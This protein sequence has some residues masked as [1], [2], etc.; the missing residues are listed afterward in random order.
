MH[1]SLV[2]TSPASSLALLTI[3]ELREAAGVSGSSQDTKLTAL[4]LRNAADITTE[5][6]I[7]VGSGGPPT[8]RRET[9][10]ETLRT[11]RAGAIA[12]SRRHEVEIASI[13]EDDVPLDAEDYVVDPESGL[14]HRLC[15]DNPIDWCARKVVIVYA[16]GFD[17]IPGDLQHAA[18]DFAR[19]SWLEK[20]RDPL[21]K[22]EEIDVEGIDR[23]KRDFWVGSVPG[24]SSEGAVPDVVAGQLKRFKNYTVG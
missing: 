2:V 4:G 16:A 9:L 13:V 19:L 12:L 18:M 23:V 14:V 3:D 20:D 22:S 5:C 21:V 6:D 7:A 17:T 10:T 24:Q 15:D 11:V 1:T 8:L